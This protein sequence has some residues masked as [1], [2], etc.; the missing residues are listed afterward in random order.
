VPVH[1]WL[2]SGRSLASVAS[3]VGWEAAAIE[4]I[5]YPDAA[6]TLVSPTRLFTQRRSRLYRVAPGGAL[7]RPKRHAPAREG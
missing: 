1:H 6:H 7:R 5:R 4:H 2:P 3:V